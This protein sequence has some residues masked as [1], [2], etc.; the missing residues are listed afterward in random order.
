MT[1]SSRRQTFLMLMFTVLLLCVAFLQTVVKSGAQSSA[2]TANS[3]VVLTTLLTL[4][5]ESIF[6]LLLKHFR[7]IETISVCAC[8]SGS[9]LTLAITFHCRRF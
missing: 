1:T 5:A 2:I 8:P 4:S 7:V 9:D 6:A 3:D